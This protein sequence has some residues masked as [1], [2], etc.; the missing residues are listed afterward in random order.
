[1]SLAMVSSR[2][3]RCPA[4]GGPA[5][6]PELIAGRTRGRASGGHQVASVK[7]LDR[8]GD[9]SPCSHHKARGQCGF[10]TSA[11]ADARA[12]ICRLPRSKPAFTDVT[13]V[14]TL[15]RSTSLLPVRFA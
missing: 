10:L 13:R 8:S 5:G 1:M 6:G 3:E 12:L 11:S 2:G 9:V 15:G 7:L 4:G 14:A